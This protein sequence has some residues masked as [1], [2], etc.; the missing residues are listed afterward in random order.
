MLRQS[1]GDTEDLVTFQRLDHITTLKY[2]ALT[3]G[4]ILADHT[5]AMWHQRAITGIQ[6]YR[7]L[8]LLHPDIIT[9]HIPIIPHSNQ[10]SRRQEQLEAIV[11]YAADNGL[12]EG[13]RLFQAARD[14]MHKERRVPVGQQTAEVINSLV[15]GLQQIRIQFT[16]NTRLFH[17]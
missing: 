14:V 4:R 8:T 1:L 16:S 7:A 11:K 5:H 17:R 15:A 12:Q 6:S 10:G 3:C 9:S 13:K 2:A